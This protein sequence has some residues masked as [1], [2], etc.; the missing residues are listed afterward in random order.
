MEGAQEGSPPRESC[1]RLEGLPAL[2][3]SLKPRGLIKKVL[4]FEVGN[5]CEWDMLDNKRV[6]NKSGHSEAL[7]Q[8]L[9]SLRDTK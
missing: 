7:S 5:R 3:S 4:S 2:F 9:T 6:P 1:L 8:F